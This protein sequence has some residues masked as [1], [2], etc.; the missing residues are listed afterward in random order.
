MITETNLLKFSVSPTIFAQNLKWRR[1][2]NANPFSPDTPKR[3]RMRMMFDAEVITILICFH[4]NT[5]R[6]FRHYYL[7]CVCGQ[8]E[9][10][11]P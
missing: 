8:R 7:S 5:Y 11:F 1:Q 9:H 6:N 10:L 4:F 3:R 2:K